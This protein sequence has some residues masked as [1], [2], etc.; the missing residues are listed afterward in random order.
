MGRVTAPQNR[1]HCYTLAVLG[2]VVYQLQYGMDI[3]RILL[4]TTTLP[5]ATEGTT[6]SLEMGPQ[7]YGPGRHIEV[8]EWT[9]PPTPSG[10]ELFNKVLTW[11]E[12]INQ[13]QQQQEKNDLGRDHDKQDAVGSI[14]H[15]EANRAISFESQDVSNTS[16]T[17]Q[18]RLDTCPCASNMMSYVQ[19]LPSPVIMQETDF[20][21]TSKRSYSEVE[22]C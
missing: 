22:T 21:E 3:S 11:T 19:P 16:S 9:S 20:V 4:Q 2:L 18:F 1:L 5:F 12:D 15:M 17:C 6:R 13:Q 8:P 10:P 7:R 14:C